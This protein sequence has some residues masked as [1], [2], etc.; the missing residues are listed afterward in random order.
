MDENK[1]I[2]ARLVRA[3]RWVK[4]PPLDC[5]NPHFKNRYAS[6]S[7][8]LDEVNKAC[9]MED[10]AYFQTLIADDGAYALHSF[11]MDMDGERVLLS[12]FPVTNSSNPQNFGSELTYKKRQ[13]AQADWC[14]VG[15]E[16]DDGEAAAKP[17]RDA[18]AG[19]SAPKPV[20]SRD[21]RLEGARGLYKQATAA[22]VKQEGIESWLVA[23]MG[24]GLKE[25][26]KLDDN[27]LHAFEAYLRGRIEDIE[28]LKGAA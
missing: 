2:Y 21:G 24:H 1:S 12:V 7:A 16:D 22:G 11:V 23:N 28:K 10:I 17:I 20:K 6:L 19:K 18:A 3:R 8:T 13:Q 25:L 15:E 27:A 4:N 5:V 14:I 26:E 9:G